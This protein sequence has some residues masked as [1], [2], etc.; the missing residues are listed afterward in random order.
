MGR[1]LKARGP[2]LVYEGE[3]RQLTLGIFEGNETLHQGIKRQ[4]EHLAVPSRETHF[5]KLHSLNSRCNS[6]LGLGRLLWEWMFGGQ[7][8]TGRG[9]GESFLAA[10][11]SDSLAKPAP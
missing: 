2:S 9:V 1:K 5:L 3:K 8:L 6:Y 7:R 10:S 11:A 4:F